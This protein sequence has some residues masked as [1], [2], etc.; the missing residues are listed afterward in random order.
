[1]NAF[2][3]SNAGEVDI[4]VTKFNPEGSTL[5]YSTY[6]GGGRVEDATGVAV[7]AAGNAYVSGT[8]NS[9]DFP[10]ASAIQA[11]FAGGHSD[12]VVFKLSPDGTA[13]RYS[14]YLGGSRQGDVSGDDEAYDIAIDGAG[15]AFVTGTITA[16]DFPVLNPIQSGL[17]LRDAFV[18]ALNPEGGL[19]YSTYLGGVWVEYGYGIAV[20]GRG[21]VYVAG[22]TSSPDFPLVGPLQDSIRG[23]SELFV[24]KMTGGNAVITVSAASF[25]PRGPLAPDSIASAFGQGLAAGIEAAASV[26]LPTSLGGVT[27]NIK[28]SKGR[29][30]LAPLFFVAP[31]Q[32]NYLVPPEVAPG[33]ASLTVLSASQTVAAGILQVAPV[34]PALFSANANGQGAAAALA[35]KVAGDGSQSIQAAY[36]CGLEA[37]SCVPAPIDLGGEADQVILV[38]FGTGIRGRSDPVAVQ[39]KIAG[40]DS[41]V[42]YAGPQPEYSGLDQINA[43]LPR[44]LAGRGEVDVE[45]TVDGAVANTVRVSV[46]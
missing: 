43:R 25:A 33:T 28:D 31:G 8:T 13:L 37:G 32:I 38:L 41:E 20:D 36:Q 39:V 12:G 30:H 23:N 7:D 21:D 17:A 5:A 3:H 15:N 9:T 44:E 2:R 46:R 34:A 24:V 6:V 22:L 29:E 42:L 40:A 26:P 14:T 19:L 10:T 11:A 45:V 27:V 16:T 1:L 18:T 35:I 4:F